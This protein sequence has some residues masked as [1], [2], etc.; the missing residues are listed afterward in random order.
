MTGGARRRSQRA[1]AHLAG[2]CSAPPCGHEARD[3]AALAVGTGADS[4]AGA[5]AMGRRTTNQAPDG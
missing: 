3:Y 1:V 2:R 5:A 4:T